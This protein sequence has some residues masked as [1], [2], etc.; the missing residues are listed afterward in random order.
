M[1][2]EKKTV[3]KADMPQ[4]VKSGEADHMSVEQW[5]AIRK[6][7][8]LHIDPETAEVGSIY[9]WLGDPYGVYGEAAVGQAER[10]CFARAPG[11]DVWV[12]FGDLPD[13]TQKALEDRIRTFPSR[14]NEYRDYDELI[15]AMA[16]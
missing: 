10:E 5:L 4:S 14:G 3:N 8:A 13:V 7:A 16:D 12:W 1:T 6:E 9:T 11:S 15:R 2:S